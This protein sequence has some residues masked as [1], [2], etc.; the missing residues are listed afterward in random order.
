MEVRPRAVLCF[1]QLPSVCPCKPQ[2]VCTFSL[3]S[4][5]VLSYF[6]PSG[7]SC[8]VRPRAVLCFLAAAMEADLRRHDAE[9]EGNFSVGPSA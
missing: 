6:R 9:I 3:L 7:I 5:Y 2:N 8:Q 4:I 1:P